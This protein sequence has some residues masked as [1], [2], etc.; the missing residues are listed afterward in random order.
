MSEWLVLGIVMAAATAVVVAVTLL[1]QRRRSLKEARGDDLRDDGVETPDV[2][3]Y[4]T[5]MVGVVYAIVLGLAIAGVWEARSVAQDEARREAQALHELVQRAEVFPADYRARLSNDVD[6]Y[7]SHVVRQEWPRMVD[8]DDVN[9]RGGELL[10]E[11]RDDVAG[12]VPRGELQ[13]QAYQPMLDRVA[14]VDEARNS[15]IQSAAATL[16]GVVWFGLIIGAL[17]TVGLIFTMNI[18]RSYQELLLAGFFSALIAFLLFLVWDFDAPFGRS[19]TDSADMFR[20][21]F[22]GAAGTAPG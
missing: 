16:P 18:G 6:A 2:L 19:G 21:L 4:M 3:E 8:G 10:D 1:N 9:G 5:M 14:I 20:Q 17:V 13:A 15:R 7:V 11:I 12:H 22:P